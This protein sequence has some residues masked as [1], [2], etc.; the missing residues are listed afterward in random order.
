MKA[1]LTVLRDLPCK[2]RRIA[3]LGDMLELG[4]MSRQLH[5]LVGDMAAESEVDALF[6]YG[7]ESFYLAQ[8]QCRKLPCITPRT[9][10]NSAV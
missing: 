6:C 1:A 4:E 7:K 2:G 5:T 9:N 10:G 3:V 8:P